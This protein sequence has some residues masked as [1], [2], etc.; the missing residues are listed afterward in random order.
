MS[1]L[2]NNFKKA[3]LLNSE[4]ALGH[5]ELLMSQ[6]LIVL[7]ADDL[8]ADVELA[9]MCSELKYDLQRAKA[10]LEVMIKRLGEK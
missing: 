2:L 3:M 7:K 10:I 1:E 8:R 5:L 4:V 9:A 6:C